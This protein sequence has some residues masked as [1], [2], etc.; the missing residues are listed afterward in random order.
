MEIRQSSRSFR[1]AI[2]VAIR[3]IV[4]GEYLYGIP[5]SRERVRYE[6]WLREFIPLYRVLDVDQST[7]ERYAEIRAQ[8]K[9]S[10]RPIPTND[11]WIAALARQHSMPLLSR[12]QHFD[13]VP[14]LKRFGW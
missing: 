14:G 4:L 13:F 5:L 10:G 8:L 1:R 2:E 9:T 3:V 6:R 7:S 12:D 11:L